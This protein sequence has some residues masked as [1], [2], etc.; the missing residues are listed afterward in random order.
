MQIR[1]RWLYAK[2]EIVAVLNEAVSETVFQKLILSLIHFLFVCFYFIDI[3]INKNV[4]FHV[5]NL[6]VYSFL[7][8]YE[9]ID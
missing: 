3:L 7:T 8:K 9:N 1:N 2:A 4:N 5:Q 6:F